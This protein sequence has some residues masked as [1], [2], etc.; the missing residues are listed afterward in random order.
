MGMASE[1]RRISRSPRGL[2]R[3]SA[4]WIMLAERRMVMA[5]GVVVGDGGVCVCVCRW[6]EDA[7][8]TV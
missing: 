4:D 2:V 5:S 3:C 7:H 6:R 1:R 8:N